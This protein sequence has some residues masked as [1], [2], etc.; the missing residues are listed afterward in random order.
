[1]IVG[2][3][4]KETIKFSVKRTSKTT[5]HLIVE[6]L[7]TYKTPN[8]TFNLKS[9]LRINLNIHGSI[10]V[11][12]KVTRMCTILGLMGT[13]RRPLKTEQE[14]TGITGE[15]MTALRDPGFHYSS[16]MKK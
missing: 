5:N 14:V 7:V 3:E 2:C 9:S 1:M 10:Y 8:T 6:F 16:A 15:E 11:H 13:L 12:L 4:D